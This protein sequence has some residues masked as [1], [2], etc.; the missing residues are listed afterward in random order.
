M[1][2][3]FKKGNVADI[4]TIIGWIGGAV[5]FILIVVNF[6][7]SFNDK[8]Q[9]MDVDSN[10]KSFMSTFTT[11]FPTAIDN[12]IVFLLLGLL[13]FSTVMAYNI[14]TDSKFLPLAIIVMVFLSA[15]AVFVSYIYVQS[16]STIL[17]TTAASLPKVDHILRHF[18]LYIIGYWLI[19]GYALYTK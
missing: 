8:I 16:T 7:S 9:S 18:V 10:S 3:L 4:G 13:V 11:N 15:A 2:N 17:A 5:F 1:K 6:N 19:V 14:E 12:G